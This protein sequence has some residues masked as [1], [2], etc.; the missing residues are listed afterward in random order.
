MITKDIS[1]QKKEN[2]KKDFK[3]KSI[4]EKEK[5]NQIKYT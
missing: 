1:R 3:T 4:Q 2:E 5:K